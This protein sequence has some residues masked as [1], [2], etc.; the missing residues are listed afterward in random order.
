[1][2]LGN[3]LFPPPSSRY[4]RSNLI[5]SLGR[6]EL[7]R[8][9]SDQQKYPTGQKGGKKWFWGMSCFPLLPLAT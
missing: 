1:M 2:V 3:E 7:G 8:R 4:L 5:W 9:G 6:G